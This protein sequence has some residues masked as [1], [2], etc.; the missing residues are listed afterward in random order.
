M[1]R[2][3]L[4]CV[5]LSALSACTILDATSPVIRGPTPAPAITVPAAVAPEGGS[6]AGGASSGSWYR[7]YFTDPPDKDD[8]K[9]RPTDTVAEAVIASLDAAART[10]DAA[11][12]DFN[13]P[14]LAEALIA[15][16]Q[17]GAVVR[18]VTDTDT[19]GED[20]VKQIK[21]AGIPVVE[22]HRSA[23]MHDKFLVIDGLVVW[24]GSW[25]FS[26]NDNYRNNNNFIGIASPEMVANYQ[27]E[28]NEMFERREFG[29]TSTANTP[30]PQFS[31]AGATIENYFSPEDDPEPKIVA[32]IQAARQSI[33]FA[34]FTFTSQAISAAVLERAQSGVVV[35]GVYETRQ[36]DAGADQSYRALKGAHLPVLLDGNR[37]TLHHKFFV[38]DGQVVVTGSFNFTRAANEE[39]DENVLII[40]NS[41]IAAQYHQEFLKVWHKAGGQ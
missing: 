9:N 35:E 2:R 7:L 29:P 15:A 13:L 39:N 21:R 40:H 12:Y 37:Y 38:I 6:Q 3:L 11:T 14:A 16:R 5:L 28:F 22:D 24:T 26:Q 20:V 18:V 17:R 27:T 10:I 32:A 4:V 8:P 19:M 1:F 41:D 30:Y 23:I 36:V 34:A 33:Y 25:N 31:L